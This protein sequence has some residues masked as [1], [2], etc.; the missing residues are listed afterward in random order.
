MGIVLLLSEQV[1][2]IKSGAFLKEFADL[3]RTK[4][5]TGC[6]AYLLSD[7]MSLTFS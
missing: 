2:V 6:V 3:D 5:I 7:L 4:T 1:S